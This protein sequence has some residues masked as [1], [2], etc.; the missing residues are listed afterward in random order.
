MEDGDESVDDV[1][2][3]E[4]PDEPDLAAPA[5][6]VIIGDL[7]LP[8]GMV[9]LLIGRQLHKVVVKRNEQLLANEHLQV[10]WF[11]LDLIMFEL[12]GPCEYLDL[13]VQDNIADVELAHLAYLNQHHHDLQLTTAAALLLE[14]LYD[15]F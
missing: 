8:T 13:L 12:A 14:L 1:V 9:Q 5:E 6:D 10:L 2:Q 11:G 4:D 3:F 7:A 15:G